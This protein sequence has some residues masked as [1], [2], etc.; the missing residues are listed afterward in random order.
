MLRVT[1]SRSN[2]HPANTTVFGGLTVFL[3]LIYFLAMSM[4]SVS[5]SAIAAIGFE[6]GTLAVRFHS[7]GTYYHH[8]VSLDLFQRFLQS[9][10]KGS[11]YNNNVRGRY[12]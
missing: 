4:I 2:Y 7:S 11:F 9:G 1:N 12:G 8:G 6:D 5:S 10:S 3:R